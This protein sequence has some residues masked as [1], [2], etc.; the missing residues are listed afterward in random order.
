MILTYRGIAYET[1]Q[2]RPSPPVQL[3]YRGKKYDR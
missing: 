2:Q 1:K 3:I